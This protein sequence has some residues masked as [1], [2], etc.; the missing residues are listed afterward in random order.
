MELGKRERG[1]TFEN[2]LA[3]DFPDSM[4]TLNPKSKNSNKFQA[5]ET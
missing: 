5:Q 1:K 4:K 2:I 3:E